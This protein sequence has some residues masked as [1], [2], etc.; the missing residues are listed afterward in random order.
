MYTQALA[1]VGLLPTS[2]VLHEQTKASSNKRVQI[3]AM[4]VLDDLQIDRTGRLGNG[5]QKNSR[6]WL[7]R[8]LRF[9]LVILCASQFVHT[10]HWR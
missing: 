1:S 3:L 10:L 5:Q 4:L 6:R 9:D 7:S 8:S 2:G